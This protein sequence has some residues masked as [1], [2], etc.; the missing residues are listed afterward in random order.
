MS[1]PV[2]RFSF[3]GANHRVFIDE[4]DRLIHI[5]VWGTWTKEEALVWRD[6]VQTCI[7]ET[8]R[9]GEKVLFAYDVTDLNVVHFADTKTFRLLIEAINDFDYDEIAV[10][11][12]SPMLM[13]SIG[14]FGGMFP[15]VK[16]IKA[17]ATE[18][19]AI[20]FLISMRDVKP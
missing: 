17:F 4:N 18:E 3:E 19:E 5:I 7:N 20:V 16:K 1:Q 10:Y 2:S 13:S 12:E 8:R 14:L 9:R 6:E 15:K 11:K